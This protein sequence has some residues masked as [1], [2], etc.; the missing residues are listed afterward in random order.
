MAIMDDSLPV[1]VPLIFVRRGREWLTRRLTEARAH[2]CSRSEQHDAVIRS[3]VWVLAG[4]AASKLIRGAS[5]LILARAFLGPADFGQFAVVSAFL[6]GIVMLSDLGIGTAVIRHPDGDTREI[7][8]S[9]FLLQAGRGVLLYCIAAALAFPFAHFYNQPVLATLALAGAAEVVVRG[10][11]S[12][13]IWTLS[14]KVRTDILSLVT[15]VGDLAGFLTAI[16]WAA[17][18]PSVWAL[19]AGRIGAALA[20]VVATHLVERRDRLYRWDWKSAKNILSFSTGMLFS[21]ATF[22]LVVEGQRLALAKF[23]TITELGCFAL[24]MSISTLPDQ[25][26]GSIVDRVFFP[27]ISQSAAD[28]PQQATAQYKNVRFLM[29]IVCGLM[30]AGFICFGPALTRIVLG[31]KYEAAQWMVQLLGIRAALMLFS[32]VTSFMLFALGYSRYAALGNISKLTFLTLGL[33]V[34]FGWFGIRQAIWVL[35]I[36]PIAS[37]LPLLFGLRRHLCGAF[38]TELACA[39]LLVGFVAVV[40]GASYTTGLLWNLAHR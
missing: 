19:I 30:A 1:S 17:I 31:P 16:T 36:A 34:A 32:S 28:D 9:A 39:A 12:S 4:V 23:I 13:S 26:I 18:A 3:S 8:D 37:H 7:L 11:T 22:F 21:S 25:F 38:R 27:M 6:T 15:A 24:A 35:S 40:N 10:F 33:T 5:T 2:L 29:L 20:Y 14:R